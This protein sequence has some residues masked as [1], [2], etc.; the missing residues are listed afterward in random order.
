MIN[1]IAEC[2][3]HMHITAELKGCWIIFLLIR[4]VMSSLYEDYSSNT[5]VD[6]YAMWWAYFP[7]GI[8]Q[9]EMYECQY[10]WLHS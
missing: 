7:R 6:I 2:I 5:V 8:C 10:L 9:C 4:A 1:I 3:V